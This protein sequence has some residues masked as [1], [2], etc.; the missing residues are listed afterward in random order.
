MEFKVNKDELKKAIMLSRKALSKAI[1]QE[2]RGHLL[3][4][5]E[6]STIFIQGTN[7]DLKSCCSI[8]IE[9]IGGKSFSFTADPKIFEKLVSKCDTKDIRIIF[10]KEEY[11]IRVYTTDTGK[12]FSTLQSFPPDKMLTIGDIKGEKRSIYPVNKEAFLFTLKFALNFMTSD[13]ED[14]KQFDLLSIKKGIC[15]ASNGSNKIGFVVFKT[16]ENISSIN[17]RKNVI[18]ILVFFI[19]K[20]DDRE[21]NIIE[22]D[23]SIGI[24]SVDNA[25]YFSF[26][27]SRMDSPELSRDHLKSIEPYV[28]IDKNDL[29]KVI[30]RVIISSTST[31]GIGIK[32]ILS[33]K[34]ENASLEI[35]LVTKKNKSI[36]VIPCIRK[37]ENEET[38]EHVVDYKLFKSI[39]GSFNTKEKI[40]FHICDNTKLFK[41]YNKGE[42]D[43]QKYILAG[44]GTFAK[45]VRK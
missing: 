11:T 16:F 43:E 6:D 22:T 1:I 23:N 18:P 38:L 24:E 21:I 9:N 35:E 13:K 31:L 5:V 20:I 29:L 27:K 15:S 12:S 40:R 3:F 14:G 39:I 4:I 17:I 26:L 42:V 34:D 44:I 41:I 36:E 8:E 25:K 45:I 30:E 7:N 28:S 2:E 19:E 37:D 10:D 32:F 33:G